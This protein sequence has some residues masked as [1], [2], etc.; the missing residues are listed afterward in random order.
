[1]PARGRGH[2]FD[3][4]DAPALA[5]ALD[6]RRHSG[7]AG[8]HPRIDPGLRDDYLP[9]AAVPG[10]GRELALALGHRA[11]SARS[12]QRSLSTRSRRNHVDG[13]RPLALR[14][15]PPASGAPAARG[16][17]R[18]PAHAPGNTRHVRYLVYASVCL[19]RGTLVST[20]RDGAGGALLLLPLPDLAG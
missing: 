16:G 7:Q 14:A 13:G 12:I 3:Y 5:L 19:D 17:R 11:F 8:P 4:D 15:C 6:G 1:G 18:P 9:G 20:R 10:T 2:L